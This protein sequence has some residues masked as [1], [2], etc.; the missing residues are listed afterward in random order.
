[1]PRS[2]LLAVQA[3]V[4]GSDSGLIV[5]IAFFCF[6][7]ALAFDCRAFCRTQSK[8]RSTHRKHIARYPEV[9]EALGQLD[10]DQAQAV[11]AIRQMMESEPETTEKNIRKDAIK[12]GVVSFLAGGAVTFVVTLLVH[13]L[14]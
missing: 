10:K 3:S 9:A 14:H 8:D 2:T 5:V 12:I 13:P 7:A 1:M 4:P 6:R 11:N